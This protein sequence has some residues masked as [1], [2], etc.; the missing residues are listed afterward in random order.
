MTFKTK[1][2]STVLLAGMSTASLNV[3]AAPSSEV[4]L[5]GILT[6]TTCNVT[7]NGGKSILNVGVFNTKVGGTDASFTAPN[8]ISAQQV[9][10]PVTLTGCAKAEKGELLIQG[11]TSVSN[12]EQNLFVAQDNQTTGFMIQDGQGQTVS[13]GKGTEV[14]MADNE[15]NA[16]YTFKVGMGTT[17][18]TPEAGTYSAPILVSYIVN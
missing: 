14:A 4:T 11:I 8:A 9:D 17:N 12:N 2:L 7:I 15:T 6:N 1:L 5:Q 13:N 3:F 10:M 18:T 16:A